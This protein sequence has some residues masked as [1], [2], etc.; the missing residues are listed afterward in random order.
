MHGNCRICRN[1]GQVL[2]HLRYSA[3]VLHGRDDKSL[4]VLCHACHT[5]IEI[6]SS[7]KKR[8]L[9]AANGELFRLS[10]LPP[11]KKLRTRYKYSKYPR[12]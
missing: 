6:D 9:Y 2:H 7:G 1:P 8:S 5:K 12:K 11:R 4:I 10:R 3:E